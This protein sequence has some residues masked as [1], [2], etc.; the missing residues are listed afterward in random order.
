MASDDKTDR[1]RAIFEPE[2]IFERFVKNANASTEEA[3]PRDDEPTGMVPNDHADTTVRP[4]PEAPA[5]VAPKAG[6]DAAASGPPPSALAPAA[7]AA[8]R[9]ACTAAS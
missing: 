5:P 8:A 7:G 6:S 4:P 1:F 3:L 9:S 2:D